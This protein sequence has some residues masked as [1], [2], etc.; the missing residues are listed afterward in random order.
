MRNQEIKF[1]NQKYS[2]IIGKNAINVLPKK[3][4][5]LCPKTKKIALIIDK[6]IPQKFKKKL[7][8]KLK[9]YNI[10]LLPFIA[11]EKNKNFNNINFFKDLAF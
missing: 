11:N 4:K 5:L 2:I 9:S 8:D 3:I 7:K 1:K 6:K 10:L